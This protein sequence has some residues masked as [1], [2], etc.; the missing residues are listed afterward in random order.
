MAGTGFYF[1]FSQGPQI[2]ATRKVLAQ[3]A[4][5]LYH[6]N[7]TPKTFEKEGN[8]ILKCFLLRPEYCPYLG[9]KSYSANRQTCTNEKSTKGLTKCEFTGILKMCTQMTPHLKEGI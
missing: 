8:K 4:A 7:D 5:F 3:P 1:T 9:M 2:R 6:N